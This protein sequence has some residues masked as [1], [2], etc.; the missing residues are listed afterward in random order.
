VTGLCLFEAK[1]TFLLVDEYVLELINEWIV[2][3]LVNVEV[4]KVIFRFRMANGQV[5]PKKAILTKR[6]WIFCPYD[7]L[8]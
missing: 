7:E 3:G 1:Y 4:V 6:E 8:L 2:N 5:C